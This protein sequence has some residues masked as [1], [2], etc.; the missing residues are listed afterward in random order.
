MSKGGGSTTTTQKSEPWSGLQPY[1]KDAYSQASNL[2][3]SG[4]PDFYPNATYVPF[5]DESQLGMSML[6]NRALQGGQ[7]DQAANWLANVAMTQRNPYIGQAGSTLTDTAKGDFLNANPYLDQ[8]YGQA[9]KNLT[10]QF[11]EGVMPGINATFGSAGRTGSGAHALAT[12][13]AVGELSD[14][15]GTM[16]ANLYGGN[17]QSERDRMMS[18]SSGLTNVG[19]ADLD[20]RFRGANL[21]LGMDQLDY[22]NIGQLMNV[23]GMVEGKAGEALSDSMNRFNFYQNRPEQAMNNYTAWLSGIP[24]NG[25]TTTTSGGGGSTLGNVVGGALTG[26]ALAGALPASMLA[27]IPGGGWALA[28]LGGLLGVL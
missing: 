25:G 3:K 19:Q 24:N 11:N 12:G 15:L 22:Q 21:G 7:H 1:L 16:A 27:A 4:G 2:Y 20:Q 5:S 28:G 8:M 14:S 23:G 26:G 9:A 18:A 13:R 6:T 10:Q 17:Y